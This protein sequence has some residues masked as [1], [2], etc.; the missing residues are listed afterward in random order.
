MLD[1]IFKY[2]RLFIILYLILLAFAGYH[3]FQIKFQYN[4]QSF[5]PTE[6]PHLSFLEEFEEKLEPDDNFLLIGIVNKPSVFEQNF[7]K[8]LDSFATQAGQI[9]YIKKV[10]SL[11]TI[12]EPIKAP[13]GFI[14]SPLIHVDE[15]GRYTQDSAKIYEDPR[16][17]DY[18]ITD[19]ATATSLLL[20]TDG[21][22]KQGQSG[23]LMDSLNQTMS[24][25]NFEETHITGRAV[26][27][28]TFLKKIREEVLFY[29]GTSSLLLLLILL[30][31]FRKPL[32]VLIP[33]VSVILGMILFFG[34][35]SF[36]GIPLG[37]M[38]TLYPSLM[39]IIGMSDVIH[40][41]SKYIDEQ[42]RNKSRIQ[43]IKNTIREIGFATLLT[44]A[45]TSIGFLALLT[46]SIEPLRNFGMYAAFGVFMA[47]FTVIFFTSMVLVEL[48]GSQLS[49]RKVQMK[50][51]NWI[52]SQMFLFVSKN[53]KR[54]TA[55]FILVL[56]LSV[57]GI[58]NVSKNVNMLSDFPKDS[59]LAKDF[60]FFEENFAGVRPMDVA[61]ITKGGQT[62]ND[63]QVMSAMQK[64]EDYLQDFD[65]VNHIISPLTVFRTINKSLNNGKSE[66]YQLPDDTSELQKIQQYSDIGKQFA[67]VISE[68]KTMG[69]ITANM[70]DIGSEK[71]KKIY[72]G[73]EQWERKNIDTSIVDFR[74]TG[75]M[76]LVDQNNDYLLN[77][78][79]TG[80]GL[81]F[82][83]V[84]FLMALLFRNF[85]MVIISF[86]PNVIP[87][88]IAGALMGFLG[89]ELK[90]T[91][92]I[93]FAIAFGIAVDDTIHF[94]S[95]FRIEQLKGAGPVRALQQTFH[96]SGKAIMLTTIILL[97]GFLN[98]ALSD[99]TVTYYIG[100]LISITLFSALFA[101]LLIAPLLIYKFFK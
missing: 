67:S 1:P 69:R 94:L 63:P 88:I 33:M 11:T 58:N 14:E 13:F 49:D 78:L 96:E 31:I 26:S 51:G 93:I 91:T 68:D 46:S 45:T 4:L 53:Q 50:G 90:A 39:L 65:A 98:L 18:L 29:I 7:I 2:N 35:L 71:M 41:M 62:I 34:T 37:I 82:L 73:I 92:S 27:Q 43:S 32:G 64:M 81:A 99:F 3:L 8:K 100:I 95:R 61:V 80:L 60:Y 84:G 86:I 17:V 28:V 97:A 59:K 36:L 20:K 6:S 9:P 66:A 16:W 47:Y 55:G 89:I 10:T 70:H 79:L 21:S 42:Y 30:V 101:D 22:L 54:I 12:K 87:L 40:I 5:F 57:W 76:Y 56:L 23:A 72:Q 77:N 24:Q 48:N 75:K 44:S 74:V 38:S 85:K 25:F 19:D 83:V 52:T 15:P